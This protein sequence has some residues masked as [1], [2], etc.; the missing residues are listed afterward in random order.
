MQ[1]RYKSEGLRERCPCRPLEK[2]DVKYLRL[3]VD[4]KYIYIYAYM[5]RLVVDMSYILTFSLPFIAHQIFM[6]CSTFQQLKN[7][8]LSNPTNMVFWYEAFEQQQGI[9][10]ILRPAREVTLTTTRGKSSYQI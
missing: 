4:A 9:W 5:W 8:D 10:I 2:Q 6:W 1:M 7:I 3:T